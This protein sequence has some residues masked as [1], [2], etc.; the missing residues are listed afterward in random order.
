[1]QRPYRG[2]LL[3]CIV[4]GIAVYLC[5]GMTGE[6]L[7]LAMGSPPA[8][9]QPMSP[10]SNT[11]STGDQFAAQF[12]SNSAIPSYMPSWASAATASA[13]QAG[14]VGEA[15]VS[16]IPVY[17]NTR[18]VP[19][20]SGYAP[21]ASVR[22]T[23]DPLYNSPRLVDRPGSSAPSP[24]PP[25]E[26]VD[27]DRPAVPF[28]ARQAVENSFQADPEAVLCEGAQILARVGPK[29]ILAS[30]VT[31]S[32][33][34]ILAP[35]K[36]KIPA[37]EMEAQRR[38]LLKKMLE[39]RI[40]L[41]LVYYDAE[42]K[43]PKENIDKIKERLGEQ[44]ELMEVPRR[45]KE[46]KLNS[47]RELEEKMIALGTSLEREK[48]AFT[49]RIVAHQWI[50][51][52]TTTDEEI[53]H[54]EMLAYYHDHAA[55]F[56]HSARARWEQLMIRKS[57]HQTAAEARATLGRMGNEVLSGVPF[58]KVAQKAS[59]G[60]TASQG[61]VW[62]WTSK[63]SLVSEALDQAIFGLPIGQLSQIIEDAQGYHIVR[64]IERQDASRTPFV[65]AQVEIRKKIREQREKGVREKYLS[66][67]REEIPVWT[68]FDGERPQK[69]NSATSLSPFLQ[70]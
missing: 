28:S 55:E 29:V 49:E 63:G 52:Q 11:S 47:R 17:S 53:S 70:R 68:I 39:Q 5:P 21:A 43:I 60:P 14:D 15:E 25:A 61:G 6:F 45:I 8:Y 22:L 35:Y 23:P 50:Q 36:D 37:S 38:L 51:Q 31:P 13:Q 64:V 10:P 44:F 33:N 62:G 7:A 42:R 65:E 59:Q 12:R 56:E 69:E 40:D 4:T 58:A 3:V 2:S 9:S 26:G 32:I 66:K 54:E 34:E 30:E 24:S 57:P 20:P 1:V 27:A 48:R 41:K 16:D 19:A 67:L 46:A 18:G